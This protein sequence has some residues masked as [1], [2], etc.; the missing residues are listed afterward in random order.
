MEIPLD[1]ASRWAY[2]LI[3]RRKAQPGRPPFQR[4]TMRQSS[5]TLLHLLLVLV[6]VAATAVIAQA[7]G[8]AHQLE[9]NPHTVPK[10]LSGSGW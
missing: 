9:R 3:H 6:F 2:R 7:A 10:A 1:I 4:R 5:T 8:F